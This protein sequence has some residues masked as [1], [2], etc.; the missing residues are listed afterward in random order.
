V[1]RS[2]DEERAQVERA[3]RVI[4]GVSLGVFVVAL[5]AIICLVLL[6]VY[7]GGHDGS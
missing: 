6:I 4:A 5:V 7:I 2:K 3:S 1:T